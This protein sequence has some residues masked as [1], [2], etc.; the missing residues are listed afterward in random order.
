VQLLYNRGLPS[1]QSTSGLVGSICMLQKQLHMW[2]QAAV[3]TCL[4]LQVNAVDFNMAGTQMASLGG[5]QNTVWD[6]TGPDGP[7]GSVPVV[8]LGHTKNCT[9]QVS[10]VLLLRSMVLRES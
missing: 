6:F 2:V 5:T 1:Q 3:L 10:Y 4:C 9:C 8:A 7:G